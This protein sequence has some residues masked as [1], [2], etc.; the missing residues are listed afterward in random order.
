[1][2]DTTDITEK[3]LTYLL[4]ESGEN[5]PYLADLL[6]WLEEARRM[7]VYGAYPP[8]T[9]MRNIELALLALSVRLD[10]G[11]GSAIREA[12]VRPPNY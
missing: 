2:T 11:T 4:N 6:R 10:A 5:G 7:Q 8:E 1:M 9:R 12:L 3:R